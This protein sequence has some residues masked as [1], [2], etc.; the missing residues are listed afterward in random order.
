MSVEL[1]LGVLTC[2][3]SS[4][5]RLAFEP[6]ETGN[7]FDTVFQEE[8]N[9]Q[10]TLPPATDGVDNLSLKPSNSFILTEPVDTPASENVVVV[11]AIEPL[12]ETTFLRRLR[13]TA[14]FCALFLAGWK[15]VACNLPSIC[16]LINLQRRL[17]RRVIALY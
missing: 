13:M 8:G 5:A 16:E 1:E 6:E 2:R 4:T 14:S 17:N 3:L 11:S 7:R 15:L 12:E 9:S 10:H